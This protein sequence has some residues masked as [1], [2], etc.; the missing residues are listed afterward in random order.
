MS[1][2]ID[3]YLGHLAELRQAVRNVLLGLTAEGLNWKPL[4]AG[5]NSVYNLAQ[6]VAWVEQWKIGH[7]LGGR[8]FPYDWSQGQ[9]L[10]SSGEDAAD[11]LFW[12]DEAATATTAVLAS[13]EPGTLD[14]APGAPIMRSAGIRQ[15]VK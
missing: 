8:P 2:E 14:R 13:L 1:N 10:N 15:S 6:H 12:L 4:P 3:F 9:D 5:T 11:L 7:M